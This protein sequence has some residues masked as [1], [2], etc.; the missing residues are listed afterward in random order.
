MLSSFSIKF[1]KESK[2]IISYLIINLVKEMNEADKQLEEENGKYAQCQI[3]FKEGESLLK[4]FM[5]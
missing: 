5:T 1:N 2:Y 4:E 3:S